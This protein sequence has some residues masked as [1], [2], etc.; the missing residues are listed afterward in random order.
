MMKQEEWGPFLRS[1]HY[2]RSL[3]LKYLA[4]P[5]NAMHFVT[6]FLHDL[7]DR[8]MTAIESAKLD[9]VGRVSQFS[10]QSNSDDVIIHLFLL[11][12]ATQY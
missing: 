2:R 9:Q 7:R 12:S 10:I 11:S 6:L 1:V 5:Q 8:W 3:N 4:V